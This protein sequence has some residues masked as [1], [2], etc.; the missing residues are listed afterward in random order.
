MAVTALEKAK[1]IAKILDDMKAL[2]INVLKIDEISSLGDY[3]VI[4]TGTSTTAVKAQADK[5]EY[6]LKQEGIMPHTVEGYRN[7]GW[8][9]IDYSDVVVHVFTEESRDFYDLDRLWQDAEKVAL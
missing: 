2:N 7:S 4:S 9:L 6:E 8:I 5:V 1:K 3:F